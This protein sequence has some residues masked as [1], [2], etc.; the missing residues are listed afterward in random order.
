[1]PPVSLA[2]HPGLDHHVAEAR[3]WL[4]LADRGKAS[5]PLAYAAFE[6]RLAIERI[7]LQYVYSSDPDGFTS[8]VLRLTGK[9]LENKIYSMAG[10]QAEINA[11][12]RVMEI[13]F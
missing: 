1:M 8:E 13:L 11:R 7:L 5:T 2:R 3:A 12:I 10:H 9:Q 4:A 6:L